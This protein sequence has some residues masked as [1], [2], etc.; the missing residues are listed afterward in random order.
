VESVRIMEEMGKRGMVKRAERKYARQEA[1]VR[2]EDNEG[3]SEEGTKEGVS[4][5]SMQKEL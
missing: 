2:D 4:E 3:V 5:D 1:I